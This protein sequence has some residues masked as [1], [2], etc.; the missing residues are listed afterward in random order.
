MQSHIKIT[1]ISFSYEKTPVLRGV[2]LDISKGERIGLIGPNG[3]GKSTILK[4]ISKV[5]PLQSGSIEI[6]NH[7]IK[8]WRQKTLAQ[9]VAIVPQD[10]YLPFMYTVEEIVL[11]GRS[12]HLGWLQFESEKDYQIAQN[13]MKRTNTYHL[14][15]R[16]F[17]ELS[18]GERQ[19]VLIARALVQEPE[20]LL[21]DEPTT[22]LD[23]N[24]QQE[25]M[26]I[27][28]SLNKEKGITTVLV[29]HDLNI[30][31][32]YCNRLIMISA[33]EVKAVGSPAEVL[34]A[35][36]LHNVYGITPQFLTHPKTSCPMVAINP[37]ISQNTKETNND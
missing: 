20:I 9:T 30:A 4:L 22:H 5:L 37:T 6:K 36:T 18:G 16:F 35:V 7:S 29:T 3:S 33:G 19:R 12:P 15:G 8:K 2:N 1:N 31:S 17:N 32:L 13:V 25:V 21:L 26:D 24:H 28:L 34:T 11:M 10:T 23:I 27:V 14:A